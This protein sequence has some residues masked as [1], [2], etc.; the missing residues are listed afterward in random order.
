MSL[1]SVIMPVYNVEDYLERSIKSILNQSYQNWEL[2]LIND[3]SKDNSGKICD[4]FSEKNNRIYSIHQENQGSG[5]ARQKGLDISK[6][7]FICFVDPDDYLEK[8]ALRNNIDKMQKYKVDV[9]A[10]SYYDKLKIN[11]KYMKKKNE[12]AII[13]LYDQDKFRKN[14]SDY[15]KVGDRSLWNKLYRSQFLKENMIEFSNLPIGQDGDFNYKVYEKLDKIYI[16]NSPYYVY[17]KTRDSS[18]TKKYRKNRLDI[19]LDLIDT[20]KKMFLEWEMYDKYEQ[21]ILLELYYALTY[22]LNNLFNTSN[23]LKYSE[24]LKK[25]KEAATRDIFSSVF[26]KLDLNYIEGTYL[27]LLFLFLKNKNYYIGCLSY[28]THLLQRKT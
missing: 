26:E 23:N 13:G 2:I 18:A 22:E 14:Y 12:V 24:K 19:E 28:Q 25:F 11:K 3:G 4:G 15:R 10:N 20:H 17:D 6:G 21:I 16:D 9:V 7:D 27:K 5:L 8:D 1:V